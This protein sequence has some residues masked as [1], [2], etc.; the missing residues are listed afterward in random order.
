MVNYNISRYITAIVVLSIVLFLVISYCGDNLSFNNLNTVWEDIATTTT[1]VTLISTLF[2]SWAWKWGIFQG[3]FVP[4]PCLSGKWS[5]LIKSTYNSDSNTI[6]VD[7]IIKHKFFSIQIQI[8]TNESSSNSTCG[9]F[10][11]EEYRGLKQLIYTYQNNPKAAI[12]ERSEIHYGTA[13]LEINED[14]S[15]LEGEYW[16]SR[17][18]TGDIRLIKS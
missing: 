7:V 12:R 15:V 11:I 1:I 2:V 8:K 10:D 9:S 14:A 18:T 17:K 13:R 5:G 6:P 3:W 4:F 16:T